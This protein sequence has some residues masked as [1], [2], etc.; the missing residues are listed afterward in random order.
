MI[1]HD[2]FPVHCTPYLAFLRKHGLPGGS[3]AGG[4]LHT[5]KQAWIFLAFQGA[6]WFCW[7]TIHTVDVIFS[8]SMS[9]AFQ[10]SVREDCGTF[11][12][13]HRQGT[14]RL[15]VTHWEGQE[16]PTQFTSVYC[17][18]SDFTGICFEKAMVFASLRLQV[19]HK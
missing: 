9:P 12:L 18:S 13:E 15:K 2:L 10:G 19:W 5:R 7:F 11:E 17:T 14:S 16:V 1:I 8:G 6:T 3:S 4:F